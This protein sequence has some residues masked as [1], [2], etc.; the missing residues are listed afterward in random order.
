M[1]L[2]NIML[3]IPT[4]TSGGAERVLCQL[5]NQ[6]A[7]RKIKVTFVNFDSRSN[8][9]HLN[10]EVRYVKLQ[11]E[12]NH[13]KKILKILEAPV[14]EVKRFFKI[15][16]L[17][18]EVKPDVVLPFCEMAEVLTIPNCLM[19]N[20]PFCI[21]VRNDYTEYYW[22]MKILSKLTYRRA[23]VVVC[24][25]DAVKDILLDSV[26]CRTAVIYNPLDESSYD[27]NISIKSRKPILLNVGRLT[28]QKNQKILIRAFSRLSR[29]HP[30]YSLYIYGCGELE[31]ELEDLISELHLKGK[32]FLKGVLNNAIL[33]NRDASAF[34]MSSDFEGFPNTLAE[35]MAN[36]IPSISTDFSTGAAR[37][38]LHNGECGWLVGVGNE[39]QLCEAMEEVIEKTDLAEEKAK[40]GLY[41]RG[42]LNADSVCQQWID[43]IEKTL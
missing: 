41:V 18:K 40:K 23:N 8:F 3:V 22:Y 13:T 27:K 16:A 1:K 24:Q 43:E 14:K 10:R 6:F 42:F 33:A 21:S 36:G 4:N 7:K 31:N 35:A 2:Q 25:T 11:T 20:V 12:F 26:K 29:R 30:E 37:I 17:I 19:L 28:P 32:V 5:A 38:L 15:R 9:Y 34:V 39:Q